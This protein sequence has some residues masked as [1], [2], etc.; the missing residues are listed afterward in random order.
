MVWFRVYLGLTDGLFSVYLGLV[1]GLFSV[2]LGLFS[3]ALGSI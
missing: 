3:V 2:G 1:W